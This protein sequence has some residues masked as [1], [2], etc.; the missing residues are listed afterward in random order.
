[1]ISS[2]GKKEAEA[3]VCLACNRVMI[4][5]GKDQ[6]GGGQSLPGL[7]QGNDLIRGKKEAEARV[8]LACNRVMISSGKDQGGGG[9]SLPGLQ[10]G[11][12]L[13]RER[14]RRRRPESAWPATG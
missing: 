10:Q 1:M 3:R 4:S 13:I 2:G 5:S 6:G 14:S 8:C 9:Q 7:Q 12:D 11:D